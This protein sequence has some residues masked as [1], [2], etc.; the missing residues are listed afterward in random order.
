MKKQDEC[1]QASLGTYL[2]NGRP[3]V[4]WCQVLK[5]ELDYRNSNTIPSIKVLPENKVAVML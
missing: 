2:V 5:D 1:S 3:A 4:E